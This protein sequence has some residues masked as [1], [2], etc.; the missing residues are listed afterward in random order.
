MLDGIEVIFTT[1]NSTDSVADTKPPCSKWGGY[2]SDGDGVRLSG[3]ESNIN[4]PINETIHW[5]SNAG[6]EAREMDNL[7]F[8]NRVFRILF[9]KEGRADLGMD[10]YLSGSQGFAKPM[11]QAI[12][13]LI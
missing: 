4:L 7:A 13:M 3:I 10:Q 2:D 6:D 11:L 8:E 5:A 9:S 12:F 1:W